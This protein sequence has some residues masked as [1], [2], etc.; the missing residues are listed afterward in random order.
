M[1]LIAGAITLACTSV[2]SPY[3]QDAC[4]KV[5]EASERSTDVYVYDQKA[6]TQFTLMAKDKADNYLG[7]NTEVIAGGA[8][9]AYR[10][11]RNKAV[12]L[13]LPN[14]GVCD[15]M[16]AHVEQE[17]YSLGWLWRIW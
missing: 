1:P 15:K 4:S 16:T 3:H 5:L 9:I 12:D 17:K 10:G 7:N 13:K 11:Y 2:V 14:M 8:V 6:E